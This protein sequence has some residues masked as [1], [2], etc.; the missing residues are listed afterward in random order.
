[1]ESREWMILLIPGEIFPEVRETALNITGS[2][3]TRIQK[4]FD[5]ERYLR[6]SPEFFPL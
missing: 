2:D 1:M 6:K 4:I 5:L 3:K